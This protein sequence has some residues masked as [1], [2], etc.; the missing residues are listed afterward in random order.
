MSSHTSSP[1]SSTKVGKLKWMRPGKHLL[2]LLLQA[3]K[4]EF[5]SDNAEELCTRIEV[6]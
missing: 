1:C 3:K 2:C 4:V 5:C 6:G